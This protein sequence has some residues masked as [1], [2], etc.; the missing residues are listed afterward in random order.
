[1]VLPLIAWGVVAGASALGAGTYFGLKGQKPDEINTFKNSYQTDYI[2]TNTDF[3]LSGS[4]IERGASISFSPNT[5]IET[6]KSAKQ[7]DAITTPT[8]NGF[9]IKTILIVGGVALGGFYLL[10]K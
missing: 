1:M 2:T 10:K 4:Q 8:M 3:D 7:E 5:T 9:D 6:K